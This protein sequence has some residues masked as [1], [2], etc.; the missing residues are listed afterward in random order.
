MEEFGFQSLMMGAIHFQFLLSDS[1]QFVGSSQ[2]RSARISFAGIF[3]CVRSFLLKHCPWSPEWVSTLLW[4]FVQITF[5]CRCVFPGHVWISQVFLVVGCLKHRRLRVWLLSLNINI[6]WSVRGRSVWRRC[7]CGLPVGWWNSLVQGVSLFGYMVMPMYS[8][9]VRPV[10]VA[11]SPLS[12]SFA[13]K[14]N[15]RC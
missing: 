12:L 4:I 13:N 10:R 15:D 8:Q 6:R 7:H 3:S 9:P 14:T 5:D 1:L 11:I 2:D